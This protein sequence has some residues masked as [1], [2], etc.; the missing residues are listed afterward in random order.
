MTGDRW[1]HNLHY[2]R[3]V[4]DAVP[5]GARTALDV[6]TG[7]G[8]LAR[9]LH[10]IVPEVTAIDL[11]AGVLERARLEDPAVDWV[12]ADA[13]TH[14]FAGTFDVVASIAV[15]HHFPDT[16]RA[17]ARMAD[18]TAPGG[19]LAVVGM[20]RSTTPLDY[21]YEV[22]GIAQHQV[23]SRTRGFWDHTA[24]TVWPPPHS[25]GEVRRLARRVLPG[26]RWRHLPLWRYALLWRKPARPGPQ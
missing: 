10:R 15:L 26:V 3:L 9:D 6:G 2:H 4:L 12:H 8:L 23:L 17:L 13:L 11:D 7:D 19:L 16:T 22:A 1:N 14:R 24:P 18:L 21:A 25:Y 20:A 5:A